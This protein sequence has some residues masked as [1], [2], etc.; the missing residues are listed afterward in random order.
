M[1]LQLKFCL[2]FPSTQIVYSLLNWPTLHPCTS[3]RSP[4]NILSKVIKTNVT[5]EPSLNIQ[6]IFYCL[7]KSGFPNWNFKENFLAAPSSGEC[8]KKPIFIIPHS[9]KDLFKFY[10]KFVPFSDIE[11]KLWDI[12][13][14]QLYNLKYNVVA[15]LI[16]S[17]TV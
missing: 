11:F 14:N 16:F 9:W 12:T 3:S 6:I 17:A 8:I 2:Q 13:E 5:K 4:Q 10:L 15:K 7:V 1:L